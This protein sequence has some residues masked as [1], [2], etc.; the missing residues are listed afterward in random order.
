MWGNERPA[1]VTQ[2]NK[3]ELHLH[4]E[5]QVQRHPQAAASSHGQ[6]PLG[7]QQGVRQ[8]DPWRAGGLQQG[9]RQLDKKSRQ[10]LHLLDGWKTRSKA[11]SAGMAAG[12]GSRRRWWIWCFLLVRGADLGILGH[13]NGSGSHETVSQQKKF[14]RQVDRLVC[15][16]VCVCAPSLKDNVSI[17]PRDNFSV[18]HFPMCCEISYRIN[19]FFVRSSTTDKKITHFFVCLIF[20][21]WTHRLTYNF[22][23]FC[24]YRQRKYQPN[25]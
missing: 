20:P 4:A 2:Q 10:K 5:Q 15:L 12:A 3:L 17:L 13:Q 1:E 22:P 6:R 25:T 19:I 23:V 9:V 21:S 11:P 8:L 14:V 7:L 16:C 24:S 18:Y